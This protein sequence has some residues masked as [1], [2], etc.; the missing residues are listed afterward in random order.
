MQSANNLI[1]L[2]CQRRGSNYTRLCPLGLKLNVSGL[3]FGRF[4]PQTYPGRSVKQS[5]HLKFWIERSAQKV[6]SRKR[7]FG[8][9][10][11][12]PDAEVSI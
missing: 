12:L 11:V 4:Y 2:G 1:E 9:P 6:E 10:Q 5:K 8:R 7:D 3:D